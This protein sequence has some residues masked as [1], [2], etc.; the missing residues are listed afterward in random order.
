MKAKK[1]VSLVLAMMLVFALAA[2]AM[3]YTPPAD[4]AYYLSTTE[5]TLAAGDKVYVSIQSNK[6]GGA[7]I[8]YFNI[9]VD[10]TT[11]GVYHVSDILYLLQN[12]DDYD[13]TFYTRP[14]DV[15]TGES[16]Y[17]YAVTDDNILDLNND[18]VV[19][20]PNYPELGRAGWMFRINDRFPLI[21]PTHPAFP[22]GY[23][24]DV[25]GPIGATIEQAYVEDEDYISLYFGLA[26]ED[27]QNTNDMNVVG[28]FNDTEEECFYF[29]VTG[30]TCYYDDTYPYF[31]HIG[32]FGRPNY[33]SLDVALNNTP[34]TAEI[35]GFSGNN[36]WYCIEDCNA[37]S[38]VN[39]LELIPMFSS[40]TGTNG[41]YLYP[42]YLNK[43]VGFMG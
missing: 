42:L 26:Q 6:I 41:T 28:V 9:E 39:Y 16:Q 23:D 37:A 12:D 34:Y 24:E 13:L 21:P 15:L 27:E 29:A 20:G 31:W 7:Y 25:R 19:F 3:A 40:Y 1:I 22:M 33:M 2:P 30:S 32:S 43:I 36:T 14:E 11:A 10:I 18:P 4:T 35:Y 5:P 38:G 8:S 17:L